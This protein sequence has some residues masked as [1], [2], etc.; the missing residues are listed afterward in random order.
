MLPSIDNWPRLT[1]WTVS[2]GPCANSWV[3]QMSRHRRS[4]D[5]LHGGHELLEVQ[6]RHRNHTQLVDLALVIWP[7]QRGRCTRYGASYI[8]RSA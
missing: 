7:R 6:C 4:P 3:G 5:A 2:Y 8:A 1:G